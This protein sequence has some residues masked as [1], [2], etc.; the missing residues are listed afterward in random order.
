MCVFTCFWLFA[1]PWTVARQAPLS[2][3]FS[4]QE[5]WNRLPFPH[6]GSFPDSEDQTC[7]LHLLDWQAKSL[8]LHCLGSPLVMN[9]LVI[10]C[11]LRF[12]T[13]I[14]FF[15][16]RNM[17]LFT[18]LLKIMVLFQLYLFR[19]A[20]NINVKCILYIFITYI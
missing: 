5:Y 11:Y 16:L 8:L 1:S 10:I 15:P 19:G 12:Y 7:L 4:R 17:G 18:L 9:S 13:W 2:V 20:V 3:T 6:P 14:F